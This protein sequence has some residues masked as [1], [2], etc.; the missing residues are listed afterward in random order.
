MATIFQTTYTQ[1]ED[2]AL[3][4]VFSE[5]YDDRRITTRFARGLVL[6][7]HGVFKV[8]GTQGNAGGSFVESPG[9]AFHQPSPALTVNTTAIATAQAT[10]ASGDLT[11]S[12]NGTVGGTVMQPGRLITLTLSN[13]ADFDAGTATVTGISALTGQSITETLVVPDGGNVTLT[14]TNYFSQVTQVKVL[15]ASMSGTGG[16]VSVGL[17]AQSAL[18]LAD[19]LGIAVR[20]PIKTGVFASNLY[21]LNGQPTNAEGNYI[22][23][24]MVP[25]LTKGGIWVFTETAVA[26]QDPIYVRIAA[27]GAGKLMLGAFRND[28]DSGNAILLPGRFTRSCAAGV[29]PAY[30]MHLG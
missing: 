5:A 17:A 4:G 18:A 30:L 27:N 13:S 20:E 12:L 7:G 16:T 14:T 6:A 10:I 9:Q 19:F 21:N 8:R 24:E 22:D 2:I 29:A 11:L 26:D 15:D 28:S 25:V 1:R 3:P 23:G